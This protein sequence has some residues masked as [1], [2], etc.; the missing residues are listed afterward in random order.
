MDT[1]TD[2]VRVYL[3][4]EHLDFY[5]AEG[6][7][8]HRRDIS[9]GAYGSEDEL[10][11]AV[12][13]LLKEGHDLLPCA[14]QRELGSRYVPARLLEWPQAAGEG[15][16]L[17]LYAKSTPEEI[18]RLLWAAAHENLLRTYGAEPTARRRLDEEW[19]AVKR[20]GSL[21]EVAVLHELTLWMKR[22]GRPFWLPGGAGA[23][24]LLYLL[25]VTR[26]DPLRCGPAEDG[27]QVI[28][29]P[30]LWPDGRPSRFEVRLAADAR[31]EVRDWLRGHWL[32]ALY[33]ELPLAYPTPDR[34]HFSHIQL[35][36]TLSD[37]EPP[38]DLPAAAGADTRAG[39]RYLRYQ[40]HIREYRLFEASF[41]SLETQ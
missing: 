38:Q 8:K 41:S 35:N 27:G 6:R 4:G 16:R 33:P 24:F 29:W 10:A 3:D 20:N 9:Y 15:G 25:G 30:V 5:L 21:P 32:F 12:E 36:F 39:R 18:G 37:T 13:R 11:G 22:E 7:G 40:A 14:G 26:G 17:M 2:K 1:N 34:I 31:E 19:Q 28:P 23:S